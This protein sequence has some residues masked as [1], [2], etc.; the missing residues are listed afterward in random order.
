MGDS[1]DV[2]FMG[3]LSV[4]MPFTSSCLV[5]S[6]FAICGVR[7][8]PGFFSKDFILEMVYNIAVY[9]KPRCC[10]GVH[11]VVAQGHRV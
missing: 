4:C 8:L 2:C 3:G 10:V 7:F 9:F 1:Q 6:N 11:K 5:V